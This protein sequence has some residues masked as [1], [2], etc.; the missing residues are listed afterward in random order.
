MSITLDATLQTAQDGIN[1]RPII[2]IISSPSAGVIPIQGSYLNTRTGAENDPNITCL[3]DGRLAG[4]YYYWTST[5]VQLKYIYTPI[6]RTEWI[7]VNVSTPYAQTVKEP[8][9]CELVDGNVGIIFVSN[10]DIYYKIISPTGTL[11]TDSTKLYESSGAWISTPYVIKLADDSYLLVVA[12]GTGTPPDQANTYTLEK[13]TSSDFT[14]W[15]GPASITLTG[16][17]A[18][19]YKNNPHLLQLSGDR[20]Y[21][22]FEYLTNLINAT[23]IQNIFS[24]YSD[25]NGSSWST[26]QQITNNTDLGTT[27]IHPVAVEDEAGT[28]TLVYVEQANVKRLDGDITGYSGTFDAD[29]L[30]FNSTDNKLYIGNYYRTTDI[31]IDTLSYER[32]YDPTTSPAIVGSGAYYDGDGH[33][34]AQEINYGVQVINHNTETVT[35]YYIAGS[36]KN[37]DCNFAYASGTMGGGFI[38]NNGEV[39]QLWTAETYGYPWDTGNIRMGYVD[40]LEILDPITGLYSFTT[41][42]DGRVGGGPTYA[43]NKQMAYIEEKDWVIMWDNKPND[44]MSGG[45]RIFDVPTGTIYGYYNPTTE[46]MD[47]VLYYNDYLYFTF[48]YSSGQADKRGLG[49]IDLATG[50]VVYFLPSWATTT[51][52]ELDNLIHLEGTTKIAMTCNHSP[53]GIAVFDTATYTWEIYNNT[54]LPGLT[55]EGCEITWSDLEYDPATETF[56]AAHQQHVLDPSGCA[57]VSVFSLTGAYASLKYLSVATPAVTPS[58]G[59]E[60]DFSI[61]YTEDQ[62]TIIYD[63]D[64]VLWILWRHRDDEE[65]SIQWANTVADKYLSDY[66]LKDSSV[67]IDWELD[68]P[69]KLKFELALGHLLDPQNLMSTYSIYLKRGREVRVRMGECVSNVDYWQNQGTFIVVEQTISYGQGYPS[70]AIIAEDMQ[71]LWEDNH[72]VATEYYNA[73]T[74]AQIIE[75][76]LEEHAQLES[77]EYNI[78]AFTGSHS[79]Y[80]QYIDMTVEEIIKSLLD[81]FMYYPFVNVDGEFEPR[82]LN[83]N[84]SVSHTYSGTT[85]IKEYSPDGKYATFI[86]RVVV[87]G[88]SN[89]Y[90]EILYE[91]EVVASESGTTGWWGKKE[92]DTVWYS[93]NHSKTC[94]YP[95][96]EVL[97]S[98]KEFAKFIRFASNKGE[99]ISSVDSDEQYCEVTI[100]APNLVPTLIACIGAAVATYSFCNHACDG[101]PHQ[102]GWCS[103]CNYAVI[104]ELNIIIYILAGVAS[105]SYN[106]WARPIGHEKQSHQDEANDYPFQNELNGKVITE[107]IDDP[108]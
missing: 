53:G 37:V 104:I 70:I 69:A 108:Y 94:R 87:K 47:S 91:E 86:N 10:N 74:P 34:T 64:Y 32:C 79:I 29:W 22:H 24:C 33:Y 93:D 105:Y 85:Q 90:S 61:E 92:D 103:A 40:L 2:E 57:F 25:D 66:I 56:F 62:P 17:S 50:N 81:H 41:V 28:L 49:Q 52:Y 13:F 71:C 46:G 77:T 30:Q 3:S 12:K 83:I 67:T 95:R 48:P 88:I 76:V 26:P 58:Y 72:V 89:L 101:G 106:I 1:H 4:V 60:A 42:F 44:L 27:I 35:K 9:I 16:L 107:T 15:T 75:N 36:N 59:T 80:H 98:V 100:E 55:E 23:E 65:Y 21:L 84:K 96:L 5:S 45:V 73:E 18:N 20:I 8:C 68:R 14:S 51:D 19:N 63:P 97:Q 11:V 31:D 54:T 99:Y 6:D 7:E 39:V 38:R 82:Y 43:D 102:K 78:S